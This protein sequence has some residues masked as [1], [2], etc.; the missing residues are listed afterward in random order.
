MSRKNPAYTYIS[1]DGMENCIRAIQNILRGDVQNCFIE[2]SA[3][4]G[5]CIGG[6][7]MRQSIKAPL[8]GY[9]AVEAYA[10][11]QDFSVDAPAGS[12][13]KVFAPAQTPS[14]RISESAIRE[15]LRKT[16]KTRPEHELNCGSCGYDTCREKAEA[17]VRGK[18]DVSMCLPFLKEKA[19]SF[20]DT[21]F[22]N[23]PNGII[24]LNEVLL[25]QQINKSAC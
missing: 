11:K 8:S 24:V 23:T 6:P 7:V 14:V 9:V 20:S 3:C 5:S 17:V 12:L 16:G 15:V 19:E 21:I 4:E 13:E 10:G 22:S 2:M 25:V 18:A 1:I